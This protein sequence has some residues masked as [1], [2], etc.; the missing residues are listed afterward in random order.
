MGWGPDDVVQERGAGALRAVLDGAQVVPLRGEAPAPAV[1][2]LPTIRIGDIPDPGPPK[3]LVKSLWTAGAFGFVGAEPKAW[4]TWVTL[5]IGICVASGRDVFGRFPVEQT[6]RVLVLSA[7]GGKGLARYRAG[8]LCRAMDLDIAQLNLEII[9]VDVLHIDKPDRA[10]ALLATVE[11]RKPS[12]LILDPLREIHTGEEND[13]GVIAGLL[14]PLRTMQAR[15][16]V[17]IMVVHHSGKAPSDGNGRKR[18]GQR[19]RGSSALHGASDSALYLSVEGDGK[20]KRVKVEAEHRAAIEPESFKL[21][22]R[23]QAFVE[24][25][26]LWLEIVDEDTDADE[27]DKAAE[28]TVAKRERDRKAILRVIR[29]ASMPSRAPLASKKSIA[30]AAKLRQATVG[31]LLDE[32]LEEGAV[33]VDKGKYRVKE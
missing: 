1:A 12:L 21:A 6:G 11:A 8:M 3:W 30:G 17:A 31:P 26:S 2:V 7:E 25:K 9:D 16:G 19:L 14:A 5:T 4:K 13:S 18:G 27:E 33:I 23:E 28:R 29:L 10:A 24:G 20:D 22:M 15:L 32:L